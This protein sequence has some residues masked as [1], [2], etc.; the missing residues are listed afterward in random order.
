[1]VLCYLVDWASRD[2][3]TLLVFVTALLFPFLRSF[4]LLLLKSWMNFFF[5]HV[6]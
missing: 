6:L 2:Y 3:G 5:W 1:M 4:F